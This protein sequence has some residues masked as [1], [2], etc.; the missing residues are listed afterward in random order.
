MIDRVVALAWLHGKRVRLGR[1]N[2]RGATAVMFDARGIGLF[3]R[4]LSARNF[5]NPNNPASFEA[6]TKAVRL[7]HR[8]APSGGAGQA[9]TK[10][11]ARAPSFQ[12]AGGPKMR[13]I[14][15]SVT[16]RDIE[17]GE[18]NVRAG[19][20]SLRN[21]AVALALQRRFK[22]KDAIWIYSTA[23]V[24]GEPFICVAGK[25]AL[26]RFIKRHDALLPVKPFRFRVRK[27]K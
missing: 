16:K 2:G 19:N 21:C 7:G 26:R 20:T 17:R 10:Q 25:A 14:Q 24:N 23:A 6:A 15:I 18:A 12:Q 3:M 13:A 8:A 5:S 27:V 1:R 9:G 11:S 22:T 4:A